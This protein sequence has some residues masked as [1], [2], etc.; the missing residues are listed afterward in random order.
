[1]LYELWEKAYIKADV[2]EFEQIILRK[3]LNRDIIIIALLNFI[4]VLNLSFR[5][6]KRE[7]FY[8]L[9]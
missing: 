8:L 3:H 2:S 5:I 9:Y 6:V 7:K 4:I 1:M